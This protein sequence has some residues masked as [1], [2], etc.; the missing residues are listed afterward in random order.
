[1]T[2]ENFGWLAEN[3]LAGMA[4]TR[5]PWWA[6]YAQDEGHTLNL[7]P[8]G[9]PFADVYELIA[10]WIPVTAG[11]YDVDMDTSM[12]T[13]YTA[14]MRPV[15]AV[16]RENIGTV[17]TH[18]LIKASDSGERLSVVGAEYAVHSYRTWLTGT[19]A[20][21]LGDE[22]VISSA[23]LLRNRAQA[24]VQ[25]ER[26]QVS[27]GPAG[28]AFAPYVVLSTSL[29]YSLA[30]QINQATTNVVCDN[31]MHMARTQGLAAS[32]KH[33]KH[34]GN[35]LGDYRSIMMR[36]VQGET[37]FR[38]ELERQLAVQ[39]DTAA[40]DRFL[41]A[42][43]PVDEEKDS[44]QKK[45]RAARKRQ[46]ITD[47]YRNDPRMMATQGTLFAV[48]QAVN[49]WETHESQLRNAT[50]DPD[51][52]DTNLRA[53]RNYARNLKPLKR[54]ELSDDEKVIQLMEAVL[55]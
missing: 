12:E 43:I 6:K 13:L 18:K 45:T 11:L 32:I 1:M 15:Q 26:P 35:M 8:A 25:V 53:M 23:G 10:S 30:S 24:W 51:I 39:V 4:E 17:D 28:I 21:V 5:P 19:V 41:D 2:Q 40:F 54:G 44:K 7:Y 52:D 33:T 27:V 50:D 36:L 3:V 34:S 55:V 42:F 29:D 47:L 16:R 48:V 22:A 46:E 31:T 37:D 49:T 38:E 20:E 14:D 9:V